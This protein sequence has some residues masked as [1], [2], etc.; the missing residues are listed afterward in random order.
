LEW[1]KSATAISSNHFY[2]FDPKFAAMMC[3][4]FLFIMTVFQLKRRFLE[5]FEADENS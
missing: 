2:H 5:Q 4:E 3:H 1:L